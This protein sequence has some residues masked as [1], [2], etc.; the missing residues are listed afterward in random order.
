[1]NTKNIAIITGAS[2]G[3][4]NALAKTY[5]KN[6]WKVITFSRTEG[7][8]PKKIHQIKVDLSNTKDLENAF[9]NAFAEV[10]LSTIKRFTLINNAG[11]LGKISPIDNISLQDISLSV[12]LNVIAVMQLSSLFI[13]KLKEVNVIKKIINISSGAAINPY[14]GWST[15]CSSKAAIEMFTKTVALE[16]QDKRYPVKINGI[17]PGVVATDMQKQI[18]ET[19]KQDF[20][21]VDKFIDLSKSNRLSNPISVAEKIYAIDVNDILNSGDIVDLREI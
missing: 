1:M 6:G 18:R 12:K 19:T 16:Q 7:D 4:G 5:Y 13:K 10:D 3:I 2:K 14:A 20:K 9:N 11:R 17:R 21:N 8:L 15:Y